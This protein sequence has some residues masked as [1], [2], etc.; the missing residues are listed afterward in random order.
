[1]SAPFIPIVE[2]THT[3]NVL[4]RIC[5]MKSLYENRLFMD[6]GRYLVTYATDD[7]PV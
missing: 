7:Q 5:A 4:Y 3:V 1:M 2:D 6:A